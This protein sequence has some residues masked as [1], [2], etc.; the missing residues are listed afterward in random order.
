MEISAEGE[1]VLFSRETGW[2]MIA[3]RLGGIIA[4]GDGEGD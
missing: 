3:V 2:R 1:A 4:A